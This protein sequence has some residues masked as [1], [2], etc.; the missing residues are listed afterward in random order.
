MPAAIW[1]FTRGVAN[2]LFGLPGEIAAHTLRAPS[3]S[4]DSAAGNAAAGVVIGTGWG[5]AR[6]GS[7]VVD[8]VTF[9]VPFEDNKPLVEPEFPL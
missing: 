4:S 7:G 5:L 8:I 6:M 3:G 1:K 2:V 9:P